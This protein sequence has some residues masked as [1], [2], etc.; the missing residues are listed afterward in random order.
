MLLADDLG[1]PPAFEVVELLKA[2]VGD[3]PVSVFAPFEQFQE[4]LTRRALPGGVL[5]Q[6]QGVPG[7]EAANRLM[8][9]VR[10][11]RR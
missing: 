3:V 11:Y 8:E 7:V 10:A 4:R 6:V 5:Y 2:R 9:E 1:F